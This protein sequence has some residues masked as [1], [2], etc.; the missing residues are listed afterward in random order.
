MVRRELENYTT[1]LRSAMGM[2]ED[3]TLTARKNATLSSTKCSHSDL[4]LLEESVVRRIVRISSTT[5]SMIAKR[6]REM[7]K[8]WKCF[9]W[10]ALWRH[11]RCFY[12][13]IRYKNLGSPILF[14]HLQ[15]HISKIQK[16]NSENITSCSCSEV[17]V[18][19]E[20]DYCHIH[21]AAAMYQTGMIHKIL[22]DTFFFFFLES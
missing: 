9:W 8:R 20:K 21:R 4:G 18:V 2:G 15:P 11:Q 3:W 19:L 17:W 13:T 7:P 12:T 5:V 14:L 16:H 22:D 10:L 6:E 1:G